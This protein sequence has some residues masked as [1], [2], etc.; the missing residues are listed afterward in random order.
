MWKEVSHLPLFFPRIRKSFA[1]VSFSMYHSLRGKRKQNRVEIRGLITGRKSADSRFY[2]LCRW[3]PVRIQTGSEFGRFE[4]IL[5]KKIRIWLY[6][7][8]LMNECNNIS[9]FE[10]IVYM[11]ILL[12]SSVDD[13][14]SNLIFL[15]FK[16][17]KI[18]KKLKISAKIKKTPSV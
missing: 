2:R 18:Q 5:S 4:W 11:N 8:Q 7:I 14:C 12:T 6:F 16:I 9:P 3:G 10:S 17:R 15:K 13:F 1:Y